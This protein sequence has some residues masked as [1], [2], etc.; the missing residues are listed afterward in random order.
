[1]HE[2]S[3]PLATTSP[4]DEPSLL[5]F[6]QLLL[7]RAEPYQRLSRW[8]AYVHQKETYLKD[9]APL[10]E[11]QERKTLINPPPPEAAK[12]LKK[13]SALRKEISRKTGAKAAEILESEAAKYETSSRKRADFDAP[14]TKRRGRKKKKTLLD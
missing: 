11:E 9:T 12:V 2:S 1:M 8:Q 7:R 10:S 3:R 5:G 14:P 13:E 6:G 4:S